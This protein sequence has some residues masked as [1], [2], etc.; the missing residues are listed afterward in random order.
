MMAWSHEETAVIF[1]I[2]SGTITRWEHQ[3][4][5]HPESETVDSLVKSR[6]PVRRYA[7][8]LRQVVH[9]MD[10]AGFGG[11]RR[12]AQTLARAG[13]KIAKDTVRR[14]RNEKPTKPTEVPMATKIRVVKARYPNHIFMADLTEV[15]GLFRIFQFKI[16]A[17]I[18]VFSR[19]P[20]AGRVFYTEHNAKAIAELF[21]EA[22]A[23]FGV[24]RHFV[25]DQGAQFTAETF[26]N[27]L[28]DGVEVRC[29]NSDKW[30]GPKKLDHCVEAWSAVTFDCVS[31]CLPLRFF[32][33]DGL[34]DEFL[35][36]LLW[37]AN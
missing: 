32:G 24:P 10:L 17:V 15:P 28:K 25:S 16:A 14:V 30:F 5:N 37:G 31:Q 7:D 23:R 20:L 34:G 19:M 12:I 29:F 27:L 6:P 13:W 3:T 1:R 35:S 4:Q 33:F 26:Q 18:D 22:V 11:K 36:F 21:R 8:V 2:S 9:S